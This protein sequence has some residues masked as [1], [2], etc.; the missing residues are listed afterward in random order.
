MMRFEIEATGKN[1]IDENSPFVFIS[2]GNFRAGFPTYKEADLYMQI[3][4]DGF[5]DGQNWEPEK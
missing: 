3:Y 4:L 5:W 2:Y 1:G